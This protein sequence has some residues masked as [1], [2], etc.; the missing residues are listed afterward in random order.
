MPRKI[1]NIYQ[2][3]WRRNLNAFEEHV[4][5]YVSCCFVAE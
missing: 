3:P 5:K 1:L 2:T 4:Q